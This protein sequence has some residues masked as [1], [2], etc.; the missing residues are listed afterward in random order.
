M[1]IHTRRPARRCA[2]GRREQSHA[3]RALIES[4]QPINTRRRAPSLRC[5]PAPGP[6]RRESAV[7]FG[8]KDKDK[9]DK[10][11]DKKD[12][13]DKKD[14]DKKDKDKKKLKNLA[15]AGGHANAL[16]PTM[17]DDVRCLTGRWRRETGPSTM[18]SRCADL[19]LSLR[20]RFASL[21]SI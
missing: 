9:K 20:L 3:T 12:T 4:C 15:I 17:P 6:R 19:R 21:S 2:I 14:K 8:K 7:M 10:D 1:Q 11:K 13:K 18:H 5:R 16:D